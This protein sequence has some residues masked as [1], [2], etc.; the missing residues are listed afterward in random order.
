M[1]IVR[2]GLFYF[3]IVCNRHLGGFNGPCPNSTPKTF[4][5]KGA[6]N[7][8]TRMTFEAS[9][10]NFHTCPSCRARLDLLEKKRNEKIPPVK[11]KL[12]T[13]TT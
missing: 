9:G 1:A 2:D 5:K 4:G 11:L 12:Q 7:L 10:D 8:A 6:E 3:R 13:V